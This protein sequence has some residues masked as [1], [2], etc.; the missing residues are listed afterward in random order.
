VKSL[1]IYSPTSGT[2]TTTLTWHLAHMFAERG[3][4][5]LLL[6]LD[7]QSTLSQMCIGMDRLGEIWQTSE[8]DQRTMYGSLAFLDELAVRVAACEPESVAPALLL[9]PGD[10]RLALLEQSL[11]DSIRGALAGESRAA[12]ILARTI[13]SVQELCESQRISLLLVDLPPD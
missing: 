11:H 4:R 7:P 9:I 2:G 13:S 6:D 5:V 10:P 1:A 3:E 12:S 8:R